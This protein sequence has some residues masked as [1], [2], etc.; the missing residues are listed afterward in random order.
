MSTAELI[1]EREQATAQVRSLPAQ[2][3]ELDGVR[4]IAI[5]LVMICHS[6]VWLSNSALRSVLVEGR[7]GV[8]LFF[9]L[10][11]FLITGILLNSQQQRRAL[12]NFYVRRALRIW[13]L[14][15]AFL[16]MTFV[17]A[18]RMVPP[19]VAVWPYLLLIQNFFYFANAG[20]LLDPTWSLAVE[21]Q[22]YVLW[23][24]IAL[25][26]SR[27]TVLKI[28]CA[29]LVVSPVLRCAL[30]LAGGSEEFVYANTL[31]RLDGIAMG[32]LI[33]AWVRI[34][35]YEVER[36]KTFARIGM[37][38]GGI[39][40][41]LCSGMA[42][43]FAT[44]LSYSFV[45]ITFG[46][47]LAWALAAQG[48]ELMTAR[49]LRSYGLT[50]MGRVSFALYLFNL[51]IYTFMHGH[52]ASRFLLFMPAAIAGVIRVVAGNV[53]LL[54]AAGVSWKFFEKPILRLKARLAPG[55]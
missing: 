51:P 2:I 53:L 3:P 30:R 5:L 26:V 44:E 28:C 37:I 19:H 7:I 39:G 18:R 29:V 10:S 33:A 12:R 48:S 23:P 21:E 22:F 4:G 1:V 20:P 54:V 27:K 14:Y 41:A 32:G 31:C 45:A 8:D 42:V 47:L 25:R 16:L 49:A 40:T 13:P 43:P 15:F 24:W 17:V 6:A 46:G 52:L 36:L 35:G 50:A 55:P 9:V 34:E 38:S 11:G